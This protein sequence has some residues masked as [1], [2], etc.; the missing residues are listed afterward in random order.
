MDVHERLWKALSFEEPDRVPTFCQTVED[1]FIERFD[2]SIG[3]DDA[4]FAS[5]TVAVARALGFDSAW[6][7]ADGATIPRD[8]PRPQVPGTATGRGL[9]LHSTGQLFQVRGFSSADA[10]Y[11]DGVLKTPGLVRDWASY[12]RSFEPPGQAFYSAVKAQWDA[13]IQRGILPVPTAGA[14][15][16]NT[17]AGTGIDRFAYMARKHPGAL[18][19]LLEAWTRHAAE[20][21]KCLF[22]RG[23]DIVIVPDDHAYK[24]RLLVSPSWWEEFVL[25]V[26]R[27]LARNARAHGAK[28]VLHSDGNITDALD[29]LVRAGV[30]AVEP[31]EHEAGMRLG[32]LKEKYHGRLALMGNV[33]A[34][35]V[36]CLGSV[37][38]TV[39]ATRRCIDEAAPGGGYVLAASANILGNA[40]IENVQAMIATAR[41]H[42]TYPLAARGGHEYL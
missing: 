10:W 27:T 36:L 33:P 38:D 4:G 40:R 3:L 24:D 25:P 21:H 11:V 39:A 31:L 32:P 12:V 30:H 18:R 19:D 14:P 23:I 35:S 8:A 16:Y 34:S 13:G 9:V 6:A 5:T 1:P 26:Y 17:W 7:H 42:G 37:D 41:A 22:E 2:E 20:Q 15:V 28:L 29:G